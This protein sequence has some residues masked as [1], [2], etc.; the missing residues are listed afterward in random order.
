MPGPH[1]SRVTIQ[2]DAATLAAGDAVATLYPAS[3]RS[4][5]MS[6]RAYYA[7]LSDQELAYSY[8]HGLCGVLATVVHQLTG[9]PVCGVYLH[10]WAWSQKALIV[11]GVCYGAAKTYPEA[12]DRQPLHV[13]VRQP[14]GR[15]YCDGW[16][17]AQSR[18]AVA[19]HYRDLG[20]RT[21]TAYSEHVRVRRTPAIDLFRGK[22]EDYALCLVE[23]VPRLIPELSEV[24]QRYAQQLG[25]SAKHTL[26]A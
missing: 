23:H 26:A 19:S 7:G 2:V 11:D 14:D 1:R 16:G 4:V 12:W 17:A 8:T 20:H 6:K 24:A 10:H 22:P 15:R 13:V 21:R 9:W 3:G 25:L 5:R 18:D